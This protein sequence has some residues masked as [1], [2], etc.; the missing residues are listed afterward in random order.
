M[1][2]YIVLKLVWWAL[3]GVL[4]IGLAVMV[5]MDMGVG[6]G[7]RYLGRTDSERR[8]VINM[9]APHWD[10]NQ[11]WFILGGGAVFA[12]WPTIYATAF[13]GLY[14][15][16]LVLLWSMIV[17]PLGF[18][19]RSKL[20]SQRW[21]NLWD[22][23]LFISGAV[24][25][26]V[27]GAAMGNMLRGVP[28]HFEWNMVSYYTGS[29]IALFNPFAVLCGL[30]SIALAL[31]QGGAMVMN[32]GTG[33]IRERACNLLTTA[34]LAALLLFTVCGLWVW[35][36]PGYVITG[37]ADPAG[38]AMPLRKT[39]ETSAGAW[40]N[41]FGAY[42]LL[43][44]VPGLVYAAVLAGVLAARRGFS[45]VAWW[46][47]ALAWAGT[48]GTVGAAMFP[49]LM[50]SSTNPG[51]SLTVW[52]ASSSA[53]TLG[54]M[55]VFT[56]IFIPIVAIYTSWAFWVMRGKVTPEQIEHDEHAY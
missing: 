17:R 36:M 48:I 55:L 31:Y 46:L 41:N 5:G 38:P 7:L 3:L 27:F 11:V 51:H 26:I 12:A 40:L 24:P 43:W 44:L 34:G 50:P 9:I 42:P 22:V 56:A 28:F 4:L 8:T 1:E 20:P 29:F 10:G 37:G 32:R 33:V 21:R 25:M 54:W 47:G 52:D 53:T 14:V 45:H 16:M 18:E 15:V 35:F 6:A 23:T 19:Y 2:I 49:F 39:V 13:S 30:M